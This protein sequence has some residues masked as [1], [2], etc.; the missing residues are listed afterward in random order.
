MSDR[1]T[2]DA[3]AAKAEDYAK[4]VARSKPDRDLRAFISTLRPGARVLDLGC[5]PGNSAAM[6][7][8]AGLEVDA[9]DASPEMV[10]I[11]RDTHGIA[12]KLATFDDLADID[13]YD[14]IWA[15]FSLLHAPRDAMPR[16]LR[17]IHVA[18]KFGGV[19]HLGLKAG[20]GS[21]R[22]SLGRHYTYYTET[23]LRGLLEDAGLAVKHVRHG[24][25]DGMAKPNEPFM[26]VT[27]I[28]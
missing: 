1:E 7:R 19:L 11:A 18:L 6:M 23:E 16:H 17:A 9:W 22:D 3:Y 8:D 25:M 14:G 21:E 5:G 10:E 12:A 13:A 15:N 27:A 20:E 4:L 26:I 24:K 2:L 28:A